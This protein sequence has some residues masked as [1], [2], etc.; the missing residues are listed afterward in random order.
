M[1]P[2]YPT[3]VA[4]L[5]YHALNFPQT[6]AYTYL[7]NGDDEVEQITYQELDR[8][9]RRIGAWL[10]AQSAAGERAL[11]LFSPG[12]DYLAAYFGC[13]YAG[14]VAVPAYPPRLNRPAPRIQAILTD[15]GARFALTTASILNNISQ[16]FAHSPELA[17]PTWLDIDSL[18]AGLEEQWQRT[19]VTPETVA[20]LQ[21]TSGSTSAP[22]GVIIRH[23]NLMHNLHQISHGFQIER[24]MSPYAD[25]TGVFWLPVYHDMGLI[26][27]MLAPMYVSRPSV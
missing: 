17:V 16:R 3:L 13:L 26:G 4:L 9:A 12:I 1:T 10:E 21:Y 2:R 27:G 8:R 20:F 22:K 5:R 6:I 25:G 19:P 14:V 18:P 23:G 15:S 11:L 7:A 24:V